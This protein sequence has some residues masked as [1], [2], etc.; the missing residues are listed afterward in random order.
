MAHLF[1]HR[2]I[3]P[4]GSVTTLH[5]LRLQMKGHCGVPT[6]VLFFFALR[7]DVSGAFV[8]LEP[9]RLPAELVSL[10]DGEG[11]DGSVGAEPVAD[12]DA[13]EEPPDGP[14]PGGPWSVRSF[15]ISLIISSSACS[16]IITVSS[17]IAL[18]SMLTI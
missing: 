2:T 13:P 5:D 12:P 6:K 18:L 10:V 3:T 11:T 14:G 4:K 17:R 8:F 16:P 7:V 9:Q 1:L 15:L